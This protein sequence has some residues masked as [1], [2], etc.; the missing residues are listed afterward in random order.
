M[1]DVLPV[2]LQ[3]SPCR[4]RGGG[5]VVAQPEH[6][7][8]VDPVRAVLEDV[9]QVRQDVVTADEDGAQGDP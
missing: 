8:A 3:P 6:G 2:V 4:G 1:G 7:K 5:D 9:Q